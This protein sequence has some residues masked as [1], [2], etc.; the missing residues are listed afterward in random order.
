M[1]RQGAQAEQTA[2]EEIQTCEYLVLLNALVGRDKD[3][4][5]MWPFVPK[6]SENSL[7]RFSRKKELI[8]T[9]APGDP[10]WQQGRI[11]VGWREG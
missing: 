10:R 1:P 9:L 11:P 7:N 4:V 5:E 6:D 3:W 8:K 2:G